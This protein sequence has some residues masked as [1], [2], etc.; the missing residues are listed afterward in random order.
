MQPCIVLNP[1][2]ATQLIRLGIDPDLIVFP[3]ADAP[4]PSRPFIDANLVADAFLRKAR[5]E[6]AIRA[7]LSVEGGPIRRDFR[8]AT[9]PPG[10]SVG[11]LP[12]FRGVDAARL[13]EIGAALRQV[14]AYTADG[15]A[16]VAELYESYIPLV[17]SHGW[18]AESVFEQERELP[19]GRKIKLPILA[20][21]TPHRGPA[22]WVF[23]GIH[24]EEPAGPNAV[25]RNV[26]VFTKLEAQG[27]PVVLIP[28]ANPR[29]YSLDWRYPNTAKRDD[30]GGVSVGD[31]DHLLP[32]LNDPTRPRLAASPSADA[33]ALTAFTLGLSKSYPPI[34]V[35]DHHEDEDLSGDP[36]YIYSHGKLGARDP[37]ARRIVR[38]LLRSGMPLAMTGTT[39][40]GEPID[41]GIVHVDQQGHPV[42]DGSIDELLTSETIIVRGRRVKGPAAKTG[43]VVETST[44]GVPIEKRIAAHAEIIRNLLRLWRLAT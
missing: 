25:A 13:K 27:V 12:V 32:S 42:K 9:S 35:V 24:G 19:G 21:T 29:G 23:A 33:A 11:G 37:V 3:Q 20:F 41:D 28:L 4:V 44:V 2:L 8:L 7:S 1:T 38:L 39:G 18:K 31:S 36:A 40:F 34:L 14:D 26:R 30:K 5:D 16:P 15:R 17:E 10:R 43:I 22:L 6:R